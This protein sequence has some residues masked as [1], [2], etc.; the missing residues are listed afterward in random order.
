MYRRLG[1]ATQSKGWGE[2]KNILLSTYSVSGTVHIMTPS[3]FETRMGR[4][5]RKWKKG[6]CHWG[7]RAVPPV[8]ESPQL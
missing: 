4:L 1:H 6:G 3:N 2:E 7:G 8:K 5:R